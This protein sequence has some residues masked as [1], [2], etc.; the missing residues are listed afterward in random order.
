[1]NDD[2]K[3]ENFH[4]DMENFV[5]LRVFVIM[6]KYLTYFVDIHQDFVGLIINVLVQLIFLYDI[7]HENKNVHVH[8]QLD[9]DRILI[10][11]LDVLNVVMMKKRN[12][13]DDKEIIDKVHDE[14][15]DL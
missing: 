7:F 11:L 15:F 10:F 5:L 8:L 9:Y 12:Y 6:N 3:L 1:M 14:I 13:N 2:M 4:F